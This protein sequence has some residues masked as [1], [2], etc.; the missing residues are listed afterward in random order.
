MDQTY[1]TELEVADVLRC[2][3]SKVKRLR[4]SGALP[5]VKGR[6]VLVSQTDLNAYIEAKTVR[7]AP[8]LE[9]E[10]IRPTNDQ[11]A[12]AWALNAVMK[13]KRYRAKSN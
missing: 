3:T 8:K 11:D 12:R 1:L 4:L 2:S 5:F 7:S 9:R 6:P 10:P 13:P